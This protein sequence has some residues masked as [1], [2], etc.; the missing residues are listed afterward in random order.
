MFETSQSKEISQVEKEK[1]KIKVLALL[2]LV[3]QEALKREVE[4][5]K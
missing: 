5:E 2:S 3:W 4:K 1:A